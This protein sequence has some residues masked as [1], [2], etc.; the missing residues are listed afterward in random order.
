VIRALSRQLLGA[1]GELELADGHVELADEV[2]VDA[3]GG[4]GLL[5][6]RVASPCSKYWTKGLRCLRRILAA[7]TSGHLGGDG[8]VG[9]D[10]EDEL[11]VVGA[12]AD[13]GVLDL[14][15]DALDG[16]VDGVDG[17]RPIS[18]SS[19]REYCS[20]AGT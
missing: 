13:A 14:V 17:I 10:L 5:G 9:P 8:A 1:D 3:G 12:L 16:R 7:S 20:L 6:G 4:G 15:A 11:V 18:C 2:L 19:R